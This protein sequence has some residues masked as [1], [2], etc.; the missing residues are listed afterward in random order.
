MPLQGLHFISVGGCFTESS[1]C[2]T[3]FIYQILCDGGTWV[4]LVYKF[5]A[6]SALISF[7]FSSVGVFRIPIY[8]VSQEERSLFWEVIVSVILSKKVYMYMCPIPN[9]F[10][11][12]AIS[13]Y[14]SKIVDKKQLLLTVSNTG[15][16]CSSDRVGTVYLV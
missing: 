16:Y 6:W 5:N 1:L 7:P 12:R 2:L 10:W 15:I 14:S 4:F 13:L 11:D 3:D 8:S 9:G